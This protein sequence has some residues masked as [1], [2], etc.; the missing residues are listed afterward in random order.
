MIK[1]VLILLFILPL[2]ILSQ[3]I[4]LNDSLSWNQPK[5]IRVNETKA[6]KCFNFSGCYYPTPESKIPSYFKQIKLTDEYQNAKIKILS[7][8]FE[9]VRSEDIQIIDIKED[10]LPNEIFVESSIYNEH[11]TPI[12]NFNFNTIRK[13]KT[14]N[15]IEKLISFEIEIELL[16]LKTKSKKSYKENSILAT[17]NWFKYSTKNSGIYKININDIKAMGLN[18]ST[19]DPSDISIFGNGGQPLPEQNGNYRIDDLKELSVYVSGG[20]DGT[21]NDN[22]YILF[23]AKSYIPWEYNNSKNI[24]YHTQNVYSDLAYYFIT[25]DKNIGEKKRIT[26]AIV[27]NDN[28]TNITNKYSNYLV[29]ENDK[30]NLQKSGRDWLG[31]LFDNKTNYSFPFVLQNYDASLPLYVNISAAAN[32]TNESTFS[33]NIG[34]STNQLSI[35]ANTLSWSKAVK[36]EKLFTFNPSS[37]SIN[38]NL[39]YN[40]PNSQSV[41]WL[42][43]IELNFRSTLTQSSP[44]FLFRDPLTVGAGNIVEYQLS[45]GNNSTIWEITD[46]HNVKKIPTT[47]LST[48]LTFKSTADSLKEFVSFN[49]QGFYTPQL[50][51]KVENQ[52]LHSLESADML[53]ITHSLFTPQAQRLAN[54]HKE[55]RGLDV[56]VVQIAEIYNEFG[57]GSPDITAIRDFVK[58]YYDKYGSTKFKYL[59]LFGDAS[60][61][62]KNI[63]GYGR[64][65]IP[66]YQ[67][68]NSTDE[69]NSWGTDDYFAIFDDNEGLG[70]SGLLDIG[71]GRFIAND[72]EQA[73]NMVDKTLRYLSKMDETNNISNPNII[74]NFNDWRNYISV[75]G[76]DE[77]GNRHVNS[78]ESLANIFENN[79]KNYNVEKIYLDAY[80]QI[81]IAGGT[82]YPD[83]EN[84]INQRMRKG[85]LLMTYVGHGG[86]LGWA[87][88]RVLKISDIISWNNQYNLPIFLTL[89]CSFS[90]YDDPATESA[91]ELVFQNKNGGAVAMFTTSRIAWDDSNETLGTHFINNGFH[92]ISGK[93]Y[94]LG[95]ITRIAKNNSYSNWVAL[96]SIVLLGD[97]SLELAYPKYNVKTTHINNNAITSTPDT[98]KS[99][100]KVT[101]KGE[102]TDNDNNKITNFNGV[103]IPTIFDKPTTIQTL[104]NDPSSSSLN[105]KSLN[106]IIFKGNVKITNGEFDFS[107]I[108]PKDIK[109]YYNFGKISYYAKSDTADA[110]GY[111][112]NIIVGGI[113]DTIIVDENSPELDLYINNTKFK[114]GDI[115]DENPL[116]LALVNDFSG[117]NITGNAIGHDAIAIL[118]EDYNNNITLNEYYESDLNSYNSGQFKYLY[119][120]LSEGIHTLRVRVWDIL[121]NS[122]EKTIEFK[123]VNSANIEIDNAFCYPNPFSNK[124]NFIFSHNQANENLSVEIIIYNSMGRLVKNIKTYTQTE[125]YKSSPIE[126][127]GKDD[128]GNKVT[129]GFYIFKIIVTNS[130]GKST[131]KTGKIIII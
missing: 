73:T 43:Y 111:F 14:S 48:N 22:D 23:Y 53:I 91:G 128:N 70:A 66:T 27:I 93:Y 19:T 31:E 77:D 117:I 55:N 102:I 40:K 34:G 110:N 37:T 75:I 1:K 20:G 45:N 109:Y 118:D 79:Y 54:N 100:S 10:E 119:K 71:V 129:N 11:K 13:N 17:G 83:V 47:I 72:I 105:F 49:G 63:L 51:G 89:T 62:F 8:K 41:G 122:T 86:G 112:D 39:T 127:D 82:R 107:F 29:Y 25:F 33:I 101:I 84:L 85:C 12:L 26:D 92:Q 120:N 46:L 131:E 56:K 116:L 97:P 42:D 114:N 78:A 5:E 99:L 96:R 28:A 80:P 21:F 65:F 76:D 4:K 60:Y 106:S 2:T 18:T 35:A 74:S 32:S 115:T 123:V 94:K 59:L 90:H 124:T 87:H 24:F 126:W 121:N 81:S 130:T 61:D 7:T 16:G 68:E 52:N 64:N 58:M 44:Q 125:G 67:N 104:Q 50:I 98:L 108:V 113:S 15:Q 95:D 36:T 57:S 88:E 6:I 38:I 69:S 103:L 3:N 30:V 9:V